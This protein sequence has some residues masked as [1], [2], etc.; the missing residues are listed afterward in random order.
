MCVPT[1]CWSL[2]SSGHEFANSQCTVPLK[3]QLLYSQGPVQIM[4]TVL[5]CVPHLAPSLSLSNKLQES[6]TQLSLSLI[7]ASNLNQLFGIYLRHQHLKKDPPILKNWL[8]LKQGEFFSIKLSYQTFPN[9]NKE[10][11][12]MKITFWDRFSATVWMHAQA[13]QAERHLTVV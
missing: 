1:S 5:H 11:E 7:Q 6:I 4:S 13:A 3:S 10:Y 8:I 2:I 12:A 9:Y